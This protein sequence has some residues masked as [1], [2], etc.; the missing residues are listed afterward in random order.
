MAFRWMAQAWSQV[1]PEIITKCFRKAGI[2]NENL[3]L[4]S[5]ELATDDDPFLMLTCSLKCKPSLSKPC[6]LTSVVKWTNT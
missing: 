3:D 4:I 5:S 6:Y 2:L 1:K